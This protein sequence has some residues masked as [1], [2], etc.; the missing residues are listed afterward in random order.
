LKEEDFMTHPQRMNS[1]TK[2]AILWQAIV[3]IAAAYELSRK[4]LE[5]ILGLSPATL[6]R[7][8]QKDG[9]IDPSS[10][11]GELAILLVRL[12]RSL[13][14]NVGGEDSAAKAWLASYNHYF[15]KCPREHIRS[16]MGLAEVVSYLDAMRG[17]L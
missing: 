10:K 7:L 12:Y 5:E 4:E 8:Y 6:S 17:K 1:L 13:S 11:K 9:S 15:N 3:N 16:I 14:A 2:G